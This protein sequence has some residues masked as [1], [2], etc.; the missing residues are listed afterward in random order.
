MFLLP[1]KINFGKTGIYQEQFDKTKS[2][3]TIKILIAVQSIHM[4]L[5]NVSIL[6]Y[7]PMV[8]LVK[9][10]NGLSCFQILFLLDTLIVL[11]GS[12]TWQAKKV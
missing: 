7:V 11:N 10:Q 9:P 8:K 5:L 1:I 3:N 12:S 2:T 4:I 6:C